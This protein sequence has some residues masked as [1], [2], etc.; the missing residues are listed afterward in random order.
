MFRQLGVIGCGL[1]GGSF[2][3]G[4]KRAGLVRRVVG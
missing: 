3:L 4:L 2:E 1:I